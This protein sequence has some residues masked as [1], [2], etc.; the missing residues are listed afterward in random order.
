[1][2]YR[3][4][5]PRRPADRA[6][7]PDQY[8]RPLQRLLPASA[9]VF[10]GASMV[11]PFQDDR[12]GL[13]A[14]FTV[15]GHPGEILYWL[16]PLCT[17]AFV[18]VVF[19]LHEVRLPIFKALL[20]GVLMLC[21]V[22]NL[23]FDRNGI[24]V[25]VGVAFWLAS[26]YM[27]FAAAMRWR[28]PRGGLKTGLTSLVLA[29][30]LSIW[31]Q[32]VYQGGNGGHIWKGGQK[33]DDSMLPSV[34]TA[35]EPAAAAPA[36]RSAETA[37][38]LN[39]LNR[40]VL[41]SVNR[42]R[43]LY[44]PWA[45]KNAEA[46]CETAVRRDYPVMLP[47]RFAEDG[48]E[49]RN[50]Q[51]SDAACNTLLYV[52]TPGL[53][54]KPDLDYRVAQ[55]HR[56]NVYL[57]LVNKKGE[58]LFK[59]TFTPDTGGVTDTAYTD[60]LN[61]GFAKMV[62]NPTPNQLLDGEYVFAKAAMPQ[63]GDTLM[64]GCAWKPV[65]SNG[66]T[67]QWGTGRINWR[68]QSLIRPENFCSKTHVGVAHLSRHPQAHLTGNAIDNRLYIKL[69]RGADLKPL[70]C[71]AVSLPLDG[72]DAEAWQAGQLQA[73]SIDI[74]PAQTDGCIGIKVKL[75]DGRTLGSP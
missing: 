26:G 40:H 50:Y 9:A 6:A 57:L 25:G 45:E 47:P 74:H 17:L 41:V 15:L 19:R 3:R 56:S 21:A 39:A 2:S 42:D 44:N 38:S 68:G 37:A 8:R 62:D 36:S 51:H 29:V 46:T 10:F 61:Q 32:D 18:P 69:F 35:A 72:S 52:G 53:S 70:E 59:H 58:E 63:Q 14:V 75:N 11:L 66:N 24:N 73:E 5:E 7:A 33:P 28:Y 65:G 55:D 49:W 30:V 54:K 27:L 34:Q 4:P 13:W 16:F 43:N 20:V 1:M 71:G 31:M 23:Y 48:Y 22:V 64:R 67:F 12:P 60:I